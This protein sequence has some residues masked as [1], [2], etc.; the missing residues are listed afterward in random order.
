MP[1]P[2]EVPPEREIAPSRFPRFT[3]ERPLET[4][5]SLEEIDKL[6]GS[7]RKRS[8]SPQAT[9]PKYRPLVNRGSIGQLFDR[10]GIVNIPSI[11]PPSGDST[12][13]VAR[14]RSKSRRS[15]SNSKEKTSDYRTRSRSD[16]AHARRKRSISHNSA[17]SARE[18]LPSR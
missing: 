17:S 18:F 8:S 13:K 9:N 10:R 4:T 15:H 6:Y 11:G 16:R 7:N 12:W 1:F 3:S 2:P 5:K 14:K